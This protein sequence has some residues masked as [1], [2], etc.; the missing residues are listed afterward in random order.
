MRTKCFCPLKAQEDL[1]LAR[2]LDTSA[3]V[4]K[5]QEEMR[6]AEIRMQQMNIERD[7]LIDKLKVC[8]KVMCSLLVHA[9]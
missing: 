2:S 6:R 1:K 9:A 5:L 3:D 7:T 8:P 4:L